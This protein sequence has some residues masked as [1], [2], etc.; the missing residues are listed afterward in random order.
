MIHD[1]V[2]LEIKIQNSLVNFN[3]KQFLIQLY[4]HNNTSD[5]NSQKMTLDRF[6]VDI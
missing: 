5:I 1:F 2:L 4:L 6:L 3:V